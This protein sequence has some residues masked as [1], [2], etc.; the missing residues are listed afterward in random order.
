MNHK[1]RGFCNFNGVFLEF[2]VK[3]CSKLINW[4]DEAD[5]LRLR[6]EMN[7]LLNK[8]YERLLSVKE[9]IKTYE[10]ALNETQTNP[11]THPETNPE[12]IEETTDTP[13]RKRLKL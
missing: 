7:T 3:V 2:D 11:E 4:M 1:K 6:D 10:D 13:T 9:E 8:T 5:V 12:A